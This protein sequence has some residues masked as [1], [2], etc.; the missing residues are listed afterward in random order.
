MRFGGHETFAIREGWLHKGMKLLME[1]P[2]RLVDAHVADW[3]GVG[4]NMAKSIRH[5]LVTTGLADPPTSRGANS[6]GY[7]PTPFG[8]LVY[9]RDPYFMELG[10]WWLLHVNVVNSVGHA[11]TWSWFFNV[12]SSGSARF[13]RPVCIEA[14]SRHLQAN[15]LR[16]PSARTLERDVACM[17][18]SY[19]RTVPPRSE[20]PEEAIESPFTD[21]GLLSHYRGTGYYQ[22]HQAAKDIPLPVFCYAVAKTTAAA[23]AEPV[24]EL[25][26]HDAT[27]APGGPGRCFA[28][29]SETLFETALR[30]EDA[31]A[32]GELELASLA[33]E[34]LL[35]IAQ[36]APLAWAKALYDG[37]DRAGGRGR[38]AA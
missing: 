35:R 6:R 33:G 36:R 5:W 19:A 13:E 17:L 1:T 25:T 15:E 22:V 10:T 37:S 18:A 28:L 4:R 16:M 3:L 31:A 9:H 21:L 23:A 27:R 7:A 2:D 8:E 14:L 32:V 20:D 11:L 30:L 34:R 38:H 26:V 24:A 29:T 12:F